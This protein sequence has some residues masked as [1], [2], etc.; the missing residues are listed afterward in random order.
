MFSSYDFGY[1]WPWTHGHLIPLAA[2]GFLALVAMR[3]KWPRW[4]AIICGVGVLWALAG[5]AVV[6]YV[7]RINRPLLLPT[8]RFLTSGSGRVLDAGAG[9]GRSALMVLLARSGA[10]VVALD[11]FSATYIDGHGPEKLHRNARAAGVDDRLEVVTGDMRSMPL[12]TGSFDAAVSAFAIDHLSS[13]GAAKALAE[14]ARVL[15]PDG[16]FML[17]IIHGDGW[18]RL[19]YPLV[20]RHMYYGRRSAL[21]RWSAR[22]SAAG[23]DIV[24]HGTPPMTLYFL[25]RKAQH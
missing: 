14:V 18:A 11:N 13:D 1:A 7:F 2:F 22:L 21:D 6:H 3:R 16:E 4:I 12:E 15:R 20:H 8:D 19:A 25:C 24:E 9:S 5:L 17:M 23:F 10:K